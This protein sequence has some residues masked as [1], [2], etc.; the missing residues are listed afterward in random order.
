[1]NKNNSLL[2][3]INNIFNVGSSLQ[4][5]NPT[6]MDKKTKIIVAT[7][8]FLLVVFVSIIA[9]VYYENYSSNKIQRYIEKEILENMHDCDNNPLVIEPVNIP[10]STLGNEYSLNFWIYVKDLQHF[11]KNPNHLG[12]ILM[13]G[14]DNGNI[15]KFF[16]HEGN[17]GIYMDTGK[18]N[19]V[20][21][22]KPEENIDLGNLAP[23]ETSLKNLRDNLAD[24]KIA[25]LRATNNM[26]ND[27]QRQIENIESDINSYREEVESNFNKGGVN[28][29]V[30]SNIPLQR[31]TCINVT[32]FNQNVDIYLDGRLK[33]SKLL[34]K[35]PA[36]LS[37]VPMI[38]GPHG[39]FDGYLSRIKFSNR[40]LTPGE[41]YKRYKEGPRITKSLKDGFQDL[42]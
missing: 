31:W 16:Y 2:N 19:L 12:N 32:V 29:I 5:N 39:G 30:L 27:F 13:R 23:G 1:M 21:C 22:F 14:L 15:G 3:N 8:V 18:N 7:V 36:V 34:P 42:F 6:G 10:S 28:N 11:H 33:N 26:K 37:A 41:I 24:A 20:F 40:A 9:Y 17:P 4:N 35:P 25:Q 38:L